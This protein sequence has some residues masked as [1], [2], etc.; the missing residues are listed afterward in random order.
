MTILIRGSEVPCHQEDAPD[1]VVRTVGSIV[2]NVLVGYLRY[3]ATG[4]ERLDYVVAACILTVVPW[5]RIR[6]IEK[7]GKIMYYIPMAV[8]FLVIEPV[9]IVPRLHFVKLVFKIETAK[10]IFNL[11]CSET[12]ILV[13]G[14]TCNS[15]AVDVIQACEDALLFN[16]EASRHYRGFEAVIILENTQSA[17]HRINH[18]IVIA[19]AH[20]LRYRTS[21]SSMSRMT[22]FE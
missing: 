14:R 21:Y 16:S 12:E 17:S 8:Y 4:D 18:P 13:I 5:F 6:I 19:T 2:R 20:C 7:I 15:I 22:F 3:G 9:S 1:V 10:Y 11:F